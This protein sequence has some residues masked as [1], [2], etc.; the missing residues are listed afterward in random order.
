M[1]LRDAAMTAGVTLVDIRGEMAAMD[2]GLKDK[3]MIVTGGS[4][5]LGAASVRRLAG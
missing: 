2:L 3:A 5:G 1:S 4:R